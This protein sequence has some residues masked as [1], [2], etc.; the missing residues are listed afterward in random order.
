MITI[1]VKIKDR[2][3]NQQVVISQYILCTS[4][5]LYGAQYS[6]TLNKYYKMIDMIIKVSKSP[7]VYN[8]E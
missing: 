8:I 2:G 7:L 6:N 3:M 5:R 4:V 1:T